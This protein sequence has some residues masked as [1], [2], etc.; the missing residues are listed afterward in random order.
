MAIPVERQ[1]AEKLPDGA[2]LQPGPP[3]PIPWTR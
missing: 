2:L 1:P 3:S